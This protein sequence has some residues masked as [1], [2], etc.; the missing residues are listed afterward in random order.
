LSFSANEISTSATF[1]GYMHGVAVG[2][3]NGD[4]NPDLALATTG[5]PDHPKVSVVLLGKW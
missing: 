1:E 3:F 2:D 4:S 5:G